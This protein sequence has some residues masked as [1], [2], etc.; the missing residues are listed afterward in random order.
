VVA[1]AA[2]GTAIWRSRWLPEA[3][4]A[5]IVL[6]LVALVGVPIL[7]D[8]YTRP[9]HYEMREVAEPARGFVTDL[10]LALALEGSA[11]H[12][13]VE[14]GEAVFLARYREALARERAAHDR[15]A[16]LSRRLGPAAAARFDEVRSL[17]ATWHAGV[18]RFL[19]G[20]PR[21]DDRGDPLQEDVYDATLVAAARLDAEIAA[22]AQDRRRQILDAERLERRLTVLLGLVA[23]IAALLTAWLGRRLHATANALRRRGQELEQVMESKARLMRGLSHDLKNP[24]NVIEGYAQLLED[25]V[26]GPT[27]EP[28]HRGAMRIRGAVG[29]LL[30]L[31]GDLLELA[32]VEAGHLSIDPHPTNVATLARNAVEE[33]RAAAAAAGHVLEVEVAADLPVVSTDARR[34]R[35]V[36]GNLVSNALKYTPPPGRIAVRAEV[37]RAEG[38]PRP[39]C[40]LAVA[41]TDSGPG[42]PRDKLGAI[43]DEFARLAPDAAPGSGLGLA[44]ARRV[45]RLLGGDITVANEVARGATF[46]LW[47]PA[48]RRGER[49]GRQ[50]ADVDAPL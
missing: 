22:A 18:D 13:Y 37:R 30:G 7:S 40:W 47:L 41:V 12:D 36:L 11:L 5:C 42:I 14:S 2:R 27:T 35:Q 45:A 50:P 33:H 16:P 43:F 49:P 32:R 3:V 34:V 19:A 38:G 46:T 6:A 48:P 15:L 26:L 17:E 4:S 8:R 21:A 31:I 28:Q 20:A 44:I 39:G 23:A 1:V 25:G 29:A 10:Q 9:L 24:L